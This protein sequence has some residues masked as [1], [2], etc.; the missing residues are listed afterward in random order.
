MIRVLAVGFETWILRPAGC[1]LLVAGC[2]LHLRVR[3][4]Y[5]AFDPIFRIRRS[6]FSVLI[7]L[8]KRT[9]YRPS[10]VTL[11]TDFD[12]RAGCHRFKRRNK[13]ENNV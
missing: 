3:F 12:N 2:W 5:G 11:V 1:W 8:L 9:V 6:G 4:F 7:F 10:G 13:R